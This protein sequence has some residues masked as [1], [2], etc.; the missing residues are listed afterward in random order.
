MNLVVQI[1][2]IF[3]LSEE[4]YRCGKTD[5]LKVSY[6]NPGPSLSYGN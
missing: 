5:V 3:Y 1:V 4:R 6:R 2:V